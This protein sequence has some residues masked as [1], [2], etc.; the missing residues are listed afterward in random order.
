[1]KE[2]LVKMPLIEIDDNEE[3]DKAETYPSVGRYLLKRANGDV[4]TV[5]VQTLKVEE[6]RAVVYECFIGQPKLYDASDIVTAEDYNALK[7]EIEDIKEAADKENDSFVKRL[8]SEFD[9]KKELLEKEHEK[10]MADLEHEYKMKMMQLDL[11]T[12][13]R[14]G[15]GEWVSGRTLLEVV[16][17]LSSGKADVQQKQERCVTNTLEEGTYKVDADCYGISEDD[18]RKIVVYPRKNYENR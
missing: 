17:T 6:N 3:W 10:R 7:D 14:F 18:G 2:A 11:D 13:K 1:M 4:S 16:R 9:K 8:Q 5:D 15:Q 12:P